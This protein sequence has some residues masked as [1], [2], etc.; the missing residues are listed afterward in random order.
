MEKESKFKLFLIIFLMIP[1]FSSTL[2][3]LQQL[4]S[5]I[6]I[7]SV[8]VS[9]NT[10]LLNLVLY[11]IQ[12]VI[13]ILI[14]KRKKMGIFLYLIF[15]IPNDIFTLFKKFNTPNLTLIHI[16]LPII[17]SIISYLIISFLLRPSWKEFN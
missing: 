8:S 3:I 4:L 14:L 11:L 7:G 13:I 17:F 12:I 15:N 2:D 5:L 6:N 16:I 9:K 10:I 1:I